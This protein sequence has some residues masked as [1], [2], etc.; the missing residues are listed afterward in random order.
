MIVLVP[1]CIGAFV[2]VLG[3]DFVAWDDD[4]NFLTNP[5]YRGL[6]WSSLKWAWT[7]FH[8]GAYQPVAWMLFELEYA[9]W[10]LRPWGYHLVSLLGHLAVCAA[11]Y[12][13]VARLLA[14]ARPAA[15]PGK[16]RLA[17]AAATALFAVHPL[18][19]EVVAW[20]TCQGYL[21]CALLA[22]VAALLY[23]Q[24]AARSEGL[25]FLDLAPSL[26]FYVASLLCHAT[27]LGL[28]VALIALD[29]YPARR[30][31]TAADWRRSV[32]EKWPFFAAGFAFA[33]LGYLAKAP[34]VRPLHALGPWQRIMQASYGACFYLVKT[35]IPAGLYAQ[36]PI[37][38]DSSALGPVFLAA[39]AALIVFST[40]VL[41]RYR[42]W[43]ALAAAWLAYLA[44][45][46][47]NS[48]LVFFGT[49]LVADRYAYLSLV[50][51]TVLAAYLLL[52][53]ATR[54]MPFALAAV[55]VIAALAVQTW[56]QCLTWRD[57]DTLWTR[58]LALDSSS[59]AAHNN[60][61]D[62]L[63]SRGRHREALEHFAAAARLDPSLTEP[64]VGSGIALAEQGKAAEASAYLAEAVRRDPGAHEA[65]AW[66]AL[67]LYDLGRKEEA[68][69]QSSRA[70][71]EGPGS[72]RTNLVRGTLLARSG[73]PDQAVPFLS[74]AL[75]LE[76]GL[77][78]ARI[79][80]GL[81]LCDLGR[82]DAAAA[83]F[84][85]V[86]EQ[87]PRSVPAHLGSGEVEWKRGEPREA[88]RWFERVLQ[89]QPSQPQARKW[90][91]RVGRGGQPAP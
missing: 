36:H 35:V 74:R 18:R 40:V 57:S 14:R 76:P 6:G 32:L 25:R 28:P 69:A 55:V 52:P 65:R 13:L 85:Q 26:L 12:A 81:A 56:R 22:I 68:L 47:P 82:L 86:L 89:L 8:L 9:I 61:G 48:G 11:L 10:G 80:L 15:D 84:R 77:A 73:Q 1:I 29:L 19:V 49:Q 27:S 54:P 64:Y 87:D 21:S 2:P 70:V 62:L 4:K 46:A 38:A 20:V 16:V 7:T 34:G 50:P 33:C 79:N 41:T 51:W 42:R 72:A 39:V 24:A 5:S 44:I 23:D 53:L 17:A 58:V 43:P 37:P 91:E 90:L 75:E 78:S 31:R 88:A 67:V 45:L 3:N 66:L 30:I 59:A 71:R 63:A 60:L 83:E